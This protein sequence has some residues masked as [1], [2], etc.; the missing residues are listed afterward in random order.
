MFRLHEVKKVKKLIV[1]FTPE[2]Q[3]RWLPD[4]NDFIQEQ[5]KTIRT[6]EATLLYRFL[7]CSECLLGGEYH[8]W[9]VFPLTTR[10]LISHF[11]VASKS[12]FITWRMR[13]KRACYAQLWKGKANFGKIREE[14]DHDGGL[15]WE[16][17]SKYASDHD[18]TGF[19]PS[20]NN[21][22]LHTLREEIVPAVFLRC[23]IIL[24]IH[25][26]LVV[27]NDDVRFFDRVNNILLC[28]VNLSMFTAK[29][30]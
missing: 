2:F 16:S 19:W 11:S 27:F 5:T 25:S 13:F 28:Y 24:T 1:K 20:D 3:S 15:L 18:L 7:F 8:C 14:K 22:R 30:L 6:R 9:V 21:T 23:G 26:F 12:N 17:K 4:P 29:G 10:S